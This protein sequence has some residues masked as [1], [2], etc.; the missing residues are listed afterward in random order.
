[1]GFSG[2]FGAYIWLDPKDVEKAAKALKI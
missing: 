1:M 2:R